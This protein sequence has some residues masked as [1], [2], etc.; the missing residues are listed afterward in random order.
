LLCH[1]EAPGA[2]RST[3]KGFAQSKGEKEE[4]EILNNEQGIMK[5]EVREMFNAQLSIINNQFIECGVAS[6]GM[7]YDQLFLACT[8]P[9]NSQ[10]LAY[11]WRVTPYHPATTPVS[12]PY[13][14]RTLGVPLP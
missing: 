10:L 12:G 5:E 4:R 1:A 6:C 9:I 2:R 8:L 11:G 13:H 7:S 3:K 14:P